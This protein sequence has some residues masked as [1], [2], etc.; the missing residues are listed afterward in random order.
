MA[1]EKNL[2]G[3]DIGSS[4][5]RAVVGSVGKDGS[6]TVDSICERPSD[7]VRNGLIVNLE[8]T[9]KA[10]TSVIQEAELQAGSEVSM[11]ISGVGG[12]SIQGRQS[13]GVTGINTKGLEITNSD[14]MRS[15]EVARTFELP[16]DRIILHTLVQDFSVD[17]KSGIKDPTSMTGH[18]LE[19]KALV[20]TGSS[21]NCQNVKKC[22][23]KAG[24]SNVRLILQQLADAD[25]VLSTD[26]KEMGS[27]LINIGSDCTNMIVYQGGVPTYVGGIDL[28]GINVTNDIAYILNKPKSVAEQVKCQHGCCFI[29]SVDPM[30]KILIPQVGGLP[31]IQLPKRELAKIIEPRM[32]EIFTLLKNNLEESNIVGSFGGGVV[33]V[34]GGSL[35]SGATELA[36]DVFKMQ[37]RIGFPED[38]PGLDR[39]Y[40]NPKYATVLGLIKAEAKKAAS[41][42]SNRG[43][44]MNN[45]SGSGFIRRLSNFFKT[46]I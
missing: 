3:L 14:I 24:I 11:V 12:S 29:P 1:S 26:E 18:R 41:G 46:V 38:L 21:A 6:L 33:L 8:Q 43:R 39:N 2:M 31:S 25:V 9:L 17:G 22:I 42:I 37:S 28:G 7:G 36:Q 40:I 45:T 19:S 32:A 44:N 30:E 13:D 34:G 23:Q 4:W 10:I 16:Q 27:I 5:I 15:L 35:L 20:I